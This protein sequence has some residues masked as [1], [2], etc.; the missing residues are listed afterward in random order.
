MKYQYIAEMMKQQTSVNIVQKEL[1]INVRKNGMVYD[2][3]HLDEIYQ[4]NATTA[5]KSR[6]ESFVWRMD[7]YNKE[8]IDLDR[9]I[10]SNRLFHLVNKAAT[11]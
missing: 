7:K 11:G 5:V 2:A 4:L 3:N 6:D 8:D 10:L 1:I 9:M